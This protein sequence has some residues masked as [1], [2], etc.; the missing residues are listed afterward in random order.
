MSA[1]QQGSMAALDRVKLYS[2]SLQNVN[3]AQVV[4]CVETF[5]GILKDEMLF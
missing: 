3:A 2:S 1:L 4:E 5:L